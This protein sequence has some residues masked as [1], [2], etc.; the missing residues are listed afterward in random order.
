MNPNLN[1]RLKQALYSL[2]KEYA[3]GP[4]SVYTAGAFTTNLVT[5][6]R[7][8]DNSV[9]VLRRAI[10]LPAT[11]AREAVQTISQI[12]ANK[13]FVVGGTF[14]TRT[15]IFIFDRPACPDLKDQDW[16]VYDDQKYEINEIGEFSNIA[17]VVKAK[18]LLDDVPNQ[19]FPMANDDL[20]EFTS[21]AEVEVV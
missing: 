11:V 1:Q 16:I 3:V 2:R 6:R 19:I 5:G 17:Y 18:Q 9:V 10:L 7:V 12:S 8:I 14:D 20:L 13:A 15:R 21:T 4:V